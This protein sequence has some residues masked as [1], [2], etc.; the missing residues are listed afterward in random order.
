[1]PLKLTLRRTFARSKKVVGER[2]RDQA[3]Q[4][5]DEEGEK[6]SLQEYKAVVSKLEDI[7]LYC[8]CTSPTC[9]SYV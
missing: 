5:Q 3:A 8:V 4:G 7:R 2:E 9:S 1:M 6:L